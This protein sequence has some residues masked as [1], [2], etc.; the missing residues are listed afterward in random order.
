MATSA[1][2]KANFE[3]VST[4]NCLIFW[5]ILKPLAKKLPCAADFYICLQLG[6]N[7]I[8]FN[9]WGILYN[10]T[11]YRILVVLGYKKSCQIQPSSSQRLTPGFR[12]LEH[13]L[14][15]IIFF[16]CSVR[17]VSIWGRLTAVF[18]FSCICWSK[19]ARA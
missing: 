12:M 10:V 7:I 2:Y 19:W 15:I 18:V 13:D 1:R 14:I 3:F 9:R 16:F 4:V 8:P 11:F 6:K 5:K 17:L